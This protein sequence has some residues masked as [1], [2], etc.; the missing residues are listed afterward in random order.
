MR[1]EEGSLFLGAGWSC[2][3][4]SC[5]PILILVICPQNPPHSMAAADGWST[6]PGAQRAVKGAVGLFGAVCD[7]SSLKAQPGNNL[8]FC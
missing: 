6:G 7:F 2:S 8:S 3:P 5:L 1:K 4:D